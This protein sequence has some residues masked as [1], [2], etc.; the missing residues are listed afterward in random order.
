MKEA[1]FCV[2]P[3]FAALRAE[4]FPLS[5]KNLRGGTDIRPPVGA[6]VKGL[7]TT[8]TLALQRVCELRALEGAYKCPLLYRLPGKIPTRNL[9]DCY[10]LLVKIL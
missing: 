2:K 9:E 3:N 7:F 5:T 1:K 6:R 4:D 8:L 10:T